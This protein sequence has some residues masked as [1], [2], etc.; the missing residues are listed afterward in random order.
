MYQTRLD[1]AVLDGAQLQGAQLGGA[2]LSAALLRKAFVWRVDARTADATDARIDSV[3]IGPK[4]RVSSTE[5][6][7]WSAAS[8]ATL[9]QRITSDSPQNAFVAAALT[10]LDRLNPVVSLAG[11]KP[12][13]KKW[14]EL[15]SLSPA[16]APYEAKLAN[17]WRQT[18]CAADG[19]P[20]VLAGII[21]TLTSDRTPFPRESSQ[22]ASLA[23]DFLKDECLGANGLSDELRENLKALRDRMSRPG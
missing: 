12:M 6:I 18:G 11:E 19:A 1:G 7:D 10:R 13:A 9:K 2:N 5:I 14:T 20:Y 22:A 4:S 8:F 23:A 15:E 17:S 3:E 21:R 16:P